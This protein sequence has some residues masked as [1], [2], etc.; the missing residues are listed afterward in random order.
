MYK[1]ILFR[2]NRGLQTK[3]LMALQKISHDFLEPGLKQGGVITLINNSIY[4]DRALVVV[5]L[6]DGIRTFSIPSTRLPYEE[7]AYYLSLDIAKEEDQPNLRNP[8]AGG[9]FVGEMG[10]ARES[11][12]LIYSK[13]RGDIEIFSIKNGVLRVGS[14][15]LKPN[16]DYPYLKEE[17]GD[18][19]DNGLTAYFEDDSNLILR[20]GTA[21]IQGREFHLEKPIRL[22]IPGLGFY[23]LSLNET[24]IFTKEST[25]DLDSITIRDSQSELLFTSN[26][27]Q[28]LA[29]RF[30]TKSGLPL[31]RVNKELSILED[32]HVRTPIENF[33]LD[34]LKR[35]ILDQREEIVRLSLNLNLLSRVGINITPDES[36]SDPNHYSS[37]YSYSDK[38]VKPYISSFIAKPLGTSVDVGPALT[39]EYLS[40]TQHEERT[41]LIPSSI[42]KWI[43]VRPHYVPKLES[44]YPDSLEFNISAGGL[45]PKR[46][47]YLGVNGVP[48]YSNPIDTD[49]GG[50]LNIAITLKD[51]PPLFSIWDQSGSLMERQVSESV[52]RYKD[53]LPPYNYVGEKITLGERLN[54]ESI[55]LKIESDVALPNLRVAS[56]YLC[57]ESLEVE[58]FI[59]ISSSDLG[60]PYTFSE[61]IYLEPGVYYILLAAH[62]EK[63]FTYLGPSQSSNS[64]IYTNGGSIQEDNDK[65]LFYRIFSITNTTQTGYIEIEGTDLSIDGSNYSVEYL[66]KEWNTSKEGASKSRLVLV[67]QEREP[68]PSI[69]LGSSYTLEREYKLPSTWVSRQWD[70]G[71]PYKTIEFTVISSS[72][73]IEVYLSPNHESWDKASI[74]SIK[75]VGHYELKYLVEYPD[76]YYLEHNNSVP[77]SKISIL[78][79]MDG[80]DTEI[81]EVSLTSVF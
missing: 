24:P 20:P 76:F 37:S 8:L 10:N 36:S 64:L 17:I 15:Y 43:D 73:D 23:I 5:P 50:E 31:Y 55:D 53:L 32:L 51:L 34:E 21:F 52:K 22:E 29:K 45:T 19:I 44:V 69:R 35:D 58:G 28:V 30:Q 54:I 25:L 61:P 74:V 67:G 7:G 48:N 14:F 39:E 60:K 4:I 3:E 1:K 6:R 42:D 66:G 2:E 71:K 72:T 78:V 56:L 49:I 38:G 79:D 33:R 57:N 62:V 63:L 12:N 70:L 77:R 46:T 81:Y 13:D 26:L 80:I 11:L 59:P 40:Q 18:H 68:I 9:P 41:A 65:S 47:Y 27:K 16:N 75:E